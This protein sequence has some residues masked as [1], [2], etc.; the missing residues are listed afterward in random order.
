MTFGYIIRATCKTAYTR[1]IRTVFYRITRSFD[2]R[3]RIRASTQANI[4]YLSAK[5]ADS[6]FRRN[7]TRRGRTHNHGTAAICISVSKQAADE[8]YA[9][10]RARVVKFRY[11]HSAVGICPINIGF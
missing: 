10:H 4:F 7:F 1:V 8:R 5:T 3:A 11:F 9:R 2:L 6:M